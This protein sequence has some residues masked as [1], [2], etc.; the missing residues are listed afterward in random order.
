MLGSSSDVD[1]GIN[2]DVT[3]EREIDRTE[4]K[5][6]SLR[7][8]LAGLAS[9]N[10]AVSEAADENAQSQAKLAGSTTAASTGLGALQAELASTRVAQEALEDSSG[11]LS[12][13]LERIP[14]R[15]GSA[16]SE[17]IEGMT[18]ELEEN[19]ERL[20]DLDMSPAE[21]DLF[22]DFNRNEVKGFVEILAETRGDIE[23]EMELIEEALG[24]GTSGENTLDS[25]VQ[26]LE[27]EGL[28][29]TTRQL[30]ELSDAMMNMDDADLE[31]DDVFGRGFQ[32][33]VPLDPTTEGFKEVFDQN[34]V[35][36]PMG[37]HIL[38]S[39]ANDDSQDLETFGDLLG[40]DPTQLSIQSRFDEMRNTDIGQLAS[41]PASPDGDPLLPDELINDLREGNIETIEELFRLTD[42]QLETRMRNM[43]SMF[44][45][46]HPTAE[47]FRE[48]ILNTLQ[49][50]DRASNANIYQANMDEISDEAL[51]EGMGQ[52]DAERL[53]DNTRRT[54]ARNTDNRNALAQLDED[55][56]LNTINEIQQQNA[57]IARR[58][59]E[60]EGP[61]DFRNS[62]SE[63]L[64]DN[65]PGRR[66]LTRLRGNTG[67]FNASEVVENM[68]VTGDARSV[69]NLIEQ[70]MP[71]D[72]TAFQREV[73]SNVLGDTRK[74]LP[75]ATVGGN[76]PLSYEA[77]EMELMQEMLE[78]ERGTEYFSELQNLLGRLQTGRLGEESRSILQNDK[79][80]EDRVVPMFSRLLPDE[81]SDQ[82]IRRIAKQFE[83]RGDPITSFLGEDSPNNISTVVGNALG[84]P[85]GDVKFGDTDT[86]LDEIDKKVKRA[87]METENL[88]EEQIKNRVMA[89]FD[90]DER[91]EF[92]RIALQSPI[93]EA[94]EGI[95]EGFEAILNDLGT[96][97]APGMFSAMTGGDT[98]YVDLLPGEEVLAEEDEENIPPQMDISP[99]RLKQL[100]QYKDS[101]SGILEE[102]ND[103][104]E[105]QV[106]TRGLAGETLGGKS[107]RRGVFG[108]LFQRSPQI[109]GT[110]DNITSKFERLDNRVGKMDTPERVRNLRRQLAGTEKRFKQIAPLLDVTS[111]SLG[112]LNIRFTNFAQTLFRLTA[113]I[114]PIIGG[115]L[116]LAGAAVTAAGAIGSFVAVGAVG[117]LEQ[118][119][120]SMAGV[121][122]R[123]E[124]ISTLVDNLRQMAYE[125]TFP[126][127]VAETANGRSGID[128]FV[129]SL[130]FGLR[131]LNRMSTIFASIMEMPDVANSIERLSDLFL[132]TGG[133]SKLASALRETVR[134]GLP[135]FV[136]ILE[137]LLPLLRGFMVNGA[138][139]AERF[140]K[141]V[142]P[143]LADTAFA[144][145]LAIA[146]GA[147]FIEVLATLLG[148]VARVTRFLTRLINV[149]PFVNVEAR[150]LAYAFGAVIGVMVILSKTL[151]TII[152]VVAKVAF[153]VVYLSDKIGALA[154]ALT[155]AKAGLLKA[156]A[157]LKAVLLPAIGV[158]IGTMGILANLIYYTIAALI[159]FKT[160][161]ALVVAVLADFVY[162]TQTGE[163]ALAGLLEK[164]E[165]FTN[166]NLFGDA[167]DNVRE[168]Y[169]G[170]A[171]VQSKI[172]NLR[173][174]FKSMF[175]PGLTQSS[176][177]RGL[178]TAQAESTRTTGGAAGLAGMASMLNI[179]VQAS[180]GDRE[181]ARMIRQEMKKM[182]KQQHGV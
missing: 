38:Y 77:L 32:S 166:I 55:S 94:T 148:V 71:N 45:Q 62:I 151:V 96:Q 11:D 139:I 85:K 103:V 76:V 93:R 123:Q 44:A 59:S 23:D 19:V 173:K 18:D 6:D 7:N 92:A 5:L 2:V 48:G 1:V 135:A 138:R 64:R 61:L 99:R 126:L 51:G 160:A 42:R 30:T 109:L 58:L 101:L 13:A 144:F 3:G 155:T 146:F 15:A 156:G 111:F 78:S 121:S 50:S 75:N 115:L 74:E 118:M 37:R 8:T 16:Q 110:I 69:S 66:I 171:R 95:E 73:L 129:D 158:L 14:D 132:G 106:L 108:M 113:L 165:Q 133:D 181:L 104:Q 39:M 56:P 125:A 43:T 49:D 169:R 88:S 112:P 46:S 98:S 100:E 131:L 150:D 162:W 31:F 4:S 34:D 107:Q 122:D 157:V 20:E 119:E 97:A 25:F 67:T 65:N 142:V 35:Q 22:S 10:I 117:F 136:R 170:I 164:A 60:A 53:L 89:S 27:S 167:A 175:F 180:R 47:R 57:N 26:R 21:R 36:P 28:E 17:L 163:S 54:L 182:L 24:G 114:G 81:F 72:I 41:A 83:E 145:G 178:G 154:G 159:S 134:R 152:S 174:T 12:E 130:R 147:G 68:D 172:N 40:L 168:F 70:N 79:Y 102:L 91:S 153:G 63:L 177:A 128:L 52:L 161:I 124:A 120:N 9:S 80:R 33:D 140:S 86:S 141:R 143:A 127:R 29:A 90:D 116:G 87:K 137:E 84:D 82:Q 179:S 105:E 176:M 149:I